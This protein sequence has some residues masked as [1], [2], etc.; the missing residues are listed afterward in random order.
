MSIN[1]NLNG[2]ISLFDAFKGKGL[3]PEELQTVEKKKKEDTKGTNK[4]QGSSSTSKKEESKK[5]ELPVNV[6]YAFQTFEI[7]TDNFGGVEKVTLEQIRTH[8]EQDYPELSKDRTHME[9]DEEK[10]LIIP[11]LKGSRKGCL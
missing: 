3:I 4:S 7:G 5:Y 1:K 9:Y 6:R 11:I 2:T 8:L 10:G